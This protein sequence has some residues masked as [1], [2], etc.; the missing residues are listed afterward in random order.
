L[1][2]PLADRRLAMEGSW[3]AFTQANDGRGDGVSGLSFADC[4]IAAVKQTAESLGLNWQN[5]ALEMGGIQLQ[6]N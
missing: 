3:V 6:F 2:T 1:K 4:D 5:N